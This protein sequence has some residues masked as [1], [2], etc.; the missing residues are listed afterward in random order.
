[1][2]SKSETD[3]GRVLTPEVNA[4]FAVQLSPHEKEVEMKYPGERAINGPRLPPLD[5]GLNENS[6]QTTAQG[7]TP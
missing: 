4:G 1:M 6:S 5:P 7:L 3:T 2:I